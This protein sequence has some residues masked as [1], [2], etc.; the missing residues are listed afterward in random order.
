[1]IPLSLL[2]MQLS[3]CPRDNAQHGTAENRCEML[4]SE[5]NSPRSL[6]LEPRKA[7]LHRGLR[8][9]VREETR[10]RGNLEKAVGHLAA[11]EMQGILQLL[12]IALRCGHKPLA[13][14]RYLRYMYLPS[15]SPSVRPTASRVATCCKKKEGLGIEVLA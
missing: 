11:E 13:I 5:W 15:F 2:S 14:L 4:H 9:K 7:R 12:P 10:G 6:G 1:M 8:T 3:L